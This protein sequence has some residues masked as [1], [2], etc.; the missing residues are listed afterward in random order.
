M[1]QM[2]RR[3]KMGALFIPIFI[4]GVFLFTLFLQLL[5]NCIMPD[6]FGVKT[7]GYWQAMG[8]FALAKILFGFNSGWGG[9]RRR[10][11]N[12]MQ[13]KWETMSPGDKEKFRD[14]WKR[15]CGKW[16][17]ENKIDPEITGVE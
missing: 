14:E 15:R 4:G 12:R 6:I 2:E 16:S 10:W 17:D 11:N 13:D 7:I 9:K 3:I 5:W 8:V 1:K